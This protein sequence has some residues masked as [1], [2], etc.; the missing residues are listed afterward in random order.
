MT[1][2]IRSLV[3]PAALLALLTATA[4]PYKFGCHYFRH[5]HHVPAVASAADRSLIDDVIA[6]SDTFDI[7]DYDIAIDITDY[8]NSGTSS[9]IPSRHRQARLR[10]AR[11]ACTCR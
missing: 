5:Q 11:T 1:L 10:S 4:Q 2:P 7:L 8:D 9:W 3:L 6:R